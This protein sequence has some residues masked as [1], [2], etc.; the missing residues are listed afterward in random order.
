MKAVEIYR[1]QY[2]SMLQQ[3]ENLILDIERLNNQI[4]VLVREAKKEN[5]DLPKVSIPS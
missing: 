3:R 1:A 4:A 2:L 5:I